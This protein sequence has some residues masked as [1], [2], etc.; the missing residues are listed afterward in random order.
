MLSL[1]TLAFAAPW[2]LA[3]LALLPALWWLLRVTPPSPRRVV[4]PPLRLLAAL[5]ARDETAVRTPWWLL[6]LRLALAACLI[7]GVARPLLNADA[8]LAGAGPVYVLIDNGWGSGDGWPQRIG[9]ALRAIDRAERQG[10]GVVLV[11]TAPPAAESGQ[12]PPTLLPAARAREL[13][14]ALTPSPWPTNRTA[15][16]AAVLQQ[17]NAGRWPPGAVILISDGLDEPSEGTAALLERMAALGPPTVLLP[18]TTSF[19]C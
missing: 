19:R 7:L 17:A 11:A 14:Q 3:A 18:N 12:P 5:A 4:F 8:T 16:V 6:L 2:A 15:A 1:G 9:E 10:R 13:A